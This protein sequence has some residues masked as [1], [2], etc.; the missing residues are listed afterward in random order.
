LNG[1]ALLLIRP[2]GFVGFRGGSVGNHDAVQKYLERVLN[3]QPLL[4]ATT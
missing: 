4:S 2:D 3:L 1:Q